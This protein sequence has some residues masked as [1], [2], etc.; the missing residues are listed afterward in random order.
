MIYLDNNATTRVDPAV[1]EVMLPWFR[2]HYANPSSLHQ[3]AEGARDALRQS[4]V[5]LGRLIGCRGDDLLWTS[6]ATEA[7]N[8]AIFGAAAALPERRHLVV[9]AVEHHAVLK[10]H[11]RLAARGYDVTLVGV[12]ARGLVDPEEVSAALRPDT[13]MVSVMLANNETGVVQPCEEIGRRCEEAGVLFLCDASQAVGKIPVSVRALRCDFLALSAHKL[14]GPK[15]VGALFR[16]R[17]APLEP[18]L[19]G[20]GQ[21]RDI[22]SGTENV[23]GIVGLGMAAYLARERLAV[24]AYAAVERLRDALETGLQASLPDVW[25]SGAG[26][27]RLPHTLHVC[28][29]GAA[30]EAL[31]QLLDEAG[32][33]ASSSSACQSNETE[34]SHVLRAMGVPTR[35]LY[36]SLRL[37][38]SLETSEDEAMRALEVLRRVVPRAVAA[39][40]TP[41]EA[42]ARFD[43]WVAAT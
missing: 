29:A 1:L 14:H 19:V 43:A 32:V 36:G 38:L 16:R 21:E 11:E 18:L 31:L 5:A 37:G 9:S 8:L 26:A 4:R 34:P 3:F 30:G 27:A 39:S 6:G 42:A 23:P 13:L 2:E 35:Y 22:R 17:G 41:G 25:V 7:C 20:G 12:D 15:G 24:G 40:T 10:P 28:F 33:C